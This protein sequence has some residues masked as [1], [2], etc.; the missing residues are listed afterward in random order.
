MDIVDEDGPDSSQRTNPDPTGPSSPASEATL[1][2]T[3][4]NAQAKLCFSEVVD[5]VVQRTQS[6]DDLKE[7]L[8]NARNHA[9]KFIW[10]QPDQIRDKDVA[11]LLRQND[12]GQSSDGTSSSPASSVAPKGQDDGKYIWSGCYFID[13]KYFPQAVTQGWIAGKCNLRRPPDLALSVADCTAYGL[14]QNHSLVQIHQDSGRA[15]I[16]KVSDRGVVEIDGEVLPSGQMHVL[17]KAST[18]IRFGDLKY[19]LEYTRFAGTESHKINLRD[20]IEAAHS[21]TNN[22]DFNLTPTPSHSNNIKIG[23]WNFTGSG[24]I[25]SGG[26][27]RVSVAMN[28]AGRIVA[29]KRVA[30][31][32]GSQTLHKR[33]GTLRILTELADAAN[34]D[35]ILRL[36]EVITDDPVGNNRSA[37]VWFVLY[38]AVAKTLNNVVDGPLLSASQGTEKTT[39]IIRS[40]LGALAFLHSH[41]WIHGDIKPTNIGIKQS[42]ASNISIVLLDLDDAI[43]APNGRMAP[44]PG[45]SGTVGWLSPERELDGFDAT[46]DVWAVGVMALWLLRGRHPWQFGINPWRSGH[47]QHRERFHDNFDGIVAFIH[48]SN[49]SALG[50]CI[51]QMIRHP[52]AHA[53]ECKQRRPTAQQALAILDMENQQDNVRGENS[54]KRHRPSTD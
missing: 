33:Q 54:A 26:E 38:P 28:D 8:D 39:T 42:D 51:L 12:S 13:L 29:M 32:R 30:A 22:I 6:N 24:T 25:G 20:Y 41:N 1:L 17:N 15:C 48:R 37:D 10:F 23:Q 50:T 18:F 4:H 36:L 7:Q 16:K 43:Y 27:G 21:T 5:W 2:L 11:L 53:A 46:T 31:A 9:R 52:Y 34:E 14:R 47:E 3:P 40:I 35:R 45:Q 19:E 49:L 44:T